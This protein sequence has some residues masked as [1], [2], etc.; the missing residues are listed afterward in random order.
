MVRTSS[1][2]LREMDWLLLWI[3]RLFWRSRYNSSDIHLNQKSSQIPGEPKKTS[4]Y[5]N[6]SRTFR[7]WSTLLMKL[8]INW[9]IYEGTAEEIRAYE[10]LL[11]SE[12]RVSVT[13]W[14]ATNGSFPWATSNFTT[15]V[16]INRLPMRIEVIKTFRH[17][18]HH[19]K[20]DGAAWTDGNAIIPIGWQF[21]LTNERLYYRNDS[22]TT[23]WIGTDT[24][25]MS[26]FK[27]I[28]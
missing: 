21:V 18:L 5:I 20:P 2:F 9:N 1:H 12:E 8:I 22:D 25:D 7:H 27:D 6:T 11:K 23:Y 13:S 24:L 28:S 10:L 17:K 19:T 14:T 3:L 26:N 15:N 4:S 16:D